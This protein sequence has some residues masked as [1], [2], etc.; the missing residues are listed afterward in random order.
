MVTIKQAIKQLWLS[1]QNVHTVYLG[2]RISII[3]LVV[4]TKFGKQVVGWGGLKWNYSAPLGIL[5]FF[6]NRRWRWGE[7][8]GKQINFLNYLFWKGSREQI[9]FKRRF[10]FEYHC[11]RD[12]KTIIIFEITIALSFRFLFGDY[13]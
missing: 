3:C 5:M 13:K 1:T 2:L 9:G 10:W 7:E 11:I 4:I 12:F 8:M 6:T